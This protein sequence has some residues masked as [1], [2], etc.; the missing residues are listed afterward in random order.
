[1]DNVFVERLWRSL[2]YEEVHLR[3]YA[4]ALEARIGIGQ[5]IA[6]YNRQRLHSALGYRTPEAVWTAGEPVPAAPKK[7]RRRKPACG[8]VDNAI[9]LPTTPQ[10]QQQQKRI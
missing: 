1:M 6:F 9:A 7:R 3:D 4:N 8:F 5:W 2:K 10:A